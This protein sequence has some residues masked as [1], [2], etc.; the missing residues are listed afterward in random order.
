MKVVI[1]FDG[2]C[3]LCNGVVQLLIKHDSQDHFRFAALQSDFGERVTSQIDQHDLDSIIVITNGKMYTKSSGALQI[4]KKMDGA[5][6][7]LY[8][9]RIIPKPIRDQLYDFLARNRHK[10][11]GRRD[12]CMMPTP[13]LKQKFLD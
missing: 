8:V 7:Y 13:E 10:I 4:V 12:S 5:W 2:V 11:F 1:L 6:K 9:L 3:N